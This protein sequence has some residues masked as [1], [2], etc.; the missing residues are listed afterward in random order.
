MYCP[1]C[2]S[3]NCMRSRRRGTMEQMLSWIGIVPFRC[4][5][6]NHRF[7]KF[8]PKFHSEEEH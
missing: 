8:Y 4:H 6:C 5:D 7:S 2:G 1:I 3:S